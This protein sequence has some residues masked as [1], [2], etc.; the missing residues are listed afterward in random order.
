MAKKVRFAVSP[1]VLAWAVGNSGRKTE[2]LEKIPM[3]K[4]WLTGEIK[5]TIQQLEKIAKKTHVPLGVLFLKEPPIEK[6]PIPCYRT[7]IDFDQPSRNL[8]D[9]V[10][11]MAYRQEWLREYLID[12][13]STPKSFVS[14][15]NINVDHR[16]VADSIRGTLDLS[17]DWASKEKKWEDALIKLCQ[18][19][20]KVGIMVVRNSI[21]GNNTHRKLNVSE[22]RGFVLVDS[23]APLVFI[24]GADFKAAQMFT[25]AHE[26]AHVWIGESAVFDLAFLHPAAQE[27]EHCCNQIAAEFLVPAKMILDQWKGLD[28]L[29]DE[30]YVLAEKYKV[31]PLVVGRRAVDLG[32]ISFK[33]YQTFY[34]YYV[35]V[36]KD[37]KSKE[38]DKGGDFY[39]TQNYRVGNLFM[40]YVVTAIREERLLFR[41]AYRLTGLKAKSFSKYAARLLGSVWEN[42]Y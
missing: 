9:T 29:I 27:I 25:L 42:E 3:L 26:L 38:D 22:F 11:L 16:V 30:L 13:G 41:D 15:F 37:K 18:A 12:D 39:R 20:E 21:V 17:N 4:R 14:S 5:P 6:L 24:N 2:L 1:K 28:N 7:F 33:E 36:I 23:Y 40:D 32:L 10:Q 19:V 31:S 35:D 8:I 34:D